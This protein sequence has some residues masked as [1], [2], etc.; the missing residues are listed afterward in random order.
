MW[1]GNLF[2]SLN[3]EYILPEPEYPLDLLSVWHKDDTRFKVVVEFRAQGLW[4][5]FLYL[6]SEH[7]VTHLSAVLSPMS[8]QTQFAFSSSI[9]LLSDIDLLW[10]L[11]H[12]QGTAQTCLVELWGHTAQHAHMAILA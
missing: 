12:R 11:W 10:R 7:A 6:G 4:L 8:C 5:H 2:L 9:L 1:C 3:S